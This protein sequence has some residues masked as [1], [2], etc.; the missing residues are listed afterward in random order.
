MNHDSA[1]ILP[2]PQ[3]REETPIAVLYRAAGRVEELRAALVAPASGNAVLAI[4]GEDRILAERMVREV[5]RQRGSWTEW[6]ICAIGCGL[7]GGRDGFSFEGRFSEAIECSPNYPLIA[8]LRDSGFGMATL[9]WIGP[10]LHGSANVPKILDG[11]PVRAW[12]TTVLVVP[13]GAL[14]RGILGI[15]DLGFT[16]LI[17]RIAGRVIL[18]RNGGPAG[19][20]WYKGPLSD[21]TRLGREES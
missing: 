2:V 16:E 20:K 10:G 12:G 13:E 11:F 9:V 3:A 19:E 8:A 6:T 7:A 14:E 15:A 21:G 18:W 17:P 4:Y 5:E 1:P